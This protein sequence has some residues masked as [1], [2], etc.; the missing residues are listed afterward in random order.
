LDVGVYTGALVDGIKRFQS[1]HGLDVDGVIGRATWRELSIP[2]AQRARQ[3]ELALERL[4]WLPHQIEGP[5]IVLNVPMFELRGWDHGWRGA[6]AFTMKAIVGR[7]ETPT[8]VLNETM[9]SVIFRP[10]WNVPF[11]ILQHEYLPAL[12]KDPGM[13]GREDMEIVRGEGDDARPVIPTD[14]NLDLLARGALR[15]RQRPGAKNALSFIKFV[16]PNEEN[17]YLHGTPAQRLF[18]RSRRAFSHG[19]VRVEDQVGLAEWV[20]AGSGEWSRERILE[21]M[22]NPAIISR[23]VRLPRPIQVIAVYITAVATPEGSVRFGPDL[24]EQ[25]AALDRALRRP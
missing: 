19:C 24:Y 13:L 17:V 6:P 9:E 10:Y 20:F 16:L 8:P 3:I 15:L 14:D 25:D 22:A 23:R 12:R 1:R 5:L 11:S 4:R 18:A 7:P 21:E 2:T